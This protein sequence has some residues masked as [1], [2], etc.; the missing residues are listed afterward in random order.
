MAVTASP[1]QQQALLDKLLMV[2]FIKV[3]Q[4]LQQVRQHQQQQVKC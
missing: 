3:V 4:V 2:F 1:E